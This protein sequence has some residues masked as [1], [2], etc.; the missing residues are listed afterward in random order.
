MQ[1][2]PCKIYG[3]GCLPNYTICRY[4]NSLNH[5]FCIQND[6]QV[7]Q[8]YSNS[9]TASSASAAVF[10]W[11]DSALARVPVVFCSNVNE[12]NNFKKYPI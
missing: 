5:H 7:H 8:P 6:T 12:K 11:E 10:P 1:G 2:K 3:C 4:V 9:T